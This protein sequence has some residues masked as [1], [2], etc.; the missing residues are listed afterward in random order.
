MDV[1]RP[2]VVQV[3]GGEPLMRRDVIDV[4]RHIN[5]DNG[6]PY[7]I[8]VSNWSLM[9]KERYLALR[10]AGVP[11]LRIETDYS[12]SDSARLTTRVEALFETVR[13]GARAGIAGNEQVDSRQNPVEGQQR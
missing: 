2:P 12:P 6:L 11:A 9:N 1:L 13:N 5:S 10:E 4:V 3:T 8:L 7:T